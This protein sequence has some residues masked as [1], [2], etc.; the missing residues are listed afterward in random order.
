MEG[1]PHPLLAIAG[2]FGLGLLHG[3]GP[4]HLAALG[5]LA[6]RKG[7]VREAVAV[8]FR[9]GAGHAG[10]LA[11]GAAAS[12]ALGFVIPEA[13]E[14]GAEIFGGSVVALLGAAAVVEALGLRVHRH[15]HGESEDHAHLHLHVGRDHVHARG[16]G[17]RHGATLVGA[18]LAVSGLRGLLLLLPVAAS[19]SPAVLGG[20][21]LAFGAGVVLSMIAAALAGAGAVRLGGRF[22]LRI[23]GRW[24]TGLVGAASFSVGVAWCVAAW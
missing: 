6:S 13:F 10:L 11:A 18:L 15:A 24:A 19:R 17:H 22:G 4:D 16:H 2:L 9:F 8:A 1:H 7:S 23:G 14:R 12:F 21:V 3:V 5:T 20:A